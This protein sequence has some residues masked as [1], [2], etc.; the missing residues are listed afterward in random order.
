[1]AATGWNG[2]SS[3]RNCNSCELSSSYSYHLLDFHLCNTTLWN[4]FL[5]TRW[6]ICQNRRWNIC[7]NISQILHKTRHCMVGTVLTARQL[8][9]SSVTKIL[10]KCY[11][12]NVQI[13]HN[14]YTNIVQIL[15]K[16]CTNIAQDKD[17]CD[18]QTTLPLL[19]I[20][21]SPKYIQLARST[22]PINNSKYIDVTYISC[23]NWWLASDA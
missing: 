17:S 12:N 14:Y 15:H 3:F 13:L 2:V 16:Y 19:R 20:H 8:S 18:C 23:S 6:N 21:L 22:K 7:Q 5:N 9:P 4:I 10:Y 1:M 11:A